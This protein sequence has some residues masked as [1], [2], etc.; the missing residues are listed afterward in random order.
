ML[1]ESRARSQAERQASIFVRNS[2]GQ[3]C[4]EVQKRRRTAA[5]RDLL[6]NERDTSASEEIALWNQGRGSFPNTVEPNAEISRLYAPTHKSYSSIW[7]SSAG[8][9]ESQADNEGYRSLNGV[10]PPMVLHAPI[11]AKQRYQPQLDK[12]YDLPGLEASRRSEVLAL[13][14]TGTHLDRFQDGAVDDDNVDLRDNSDITT[15]PSSE[16]AKIFLLES[17]EYRWLLTSIRRHLSMAF[18]NGLC[19]VS[20]AF[21]ESLRGLVTSTGSNGHSLCLDVDWTPF[22]LINDQ[23]EPV[24]QNFNL[25]DVI[26][27]SGGASDAFATTC[28]EYMGLIWPS[29]GP[30]S[31]E[32]V[33]AA[34]VSEAGT[35]SVEVD[36]VQIR[37]NCKDTRTTIESMG[38]AVALLEIFEA[39]T[40]LG[41]ACRVSPETGALSFCAPTISKKSS[42][43]L[44]FQIKYV[45]S[46]IEVEMQSEAGAACWHNMFR[47]P[48]IAKG[49][50]VPRRHNN[51]PGLELSLDMMATLGQTFW[52]TC[53][54]GFLLKGFNSIAAPVKRTGKSV[55]WHFLVKKDKTRMSYEDT[56]QYCGLSSIRDAIFAGARHFIGWAEQVEIIAGRSMISLKWSCDVHWSRF[57]TNDASQVS[58]ALFGGASTCL[59]NVELLKTTQL[60]LLL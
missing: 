38:T 49:F 52:A 8:R 39:V 40:W 34:M 60:M 21:M 19:E 24:G 23:L 37:V 44:D 47:N 36:G 54:D 45:S 4:T 20:K 27:L 2:R 51:E 25:S 42:G 11:N 13:S 35:A 14:P 32:C 41:A 16:E 26:T 33:Q 50:P 28:A 6:P 12:S 31:L 55:L 3:I 15:I 56:R 59:C 5:T 17:E 53:Y 43:C 7:N 48:A 57:G 9:P 29:Y 58:S 18:A 22:S 1:L 10:H 30:T 46:S